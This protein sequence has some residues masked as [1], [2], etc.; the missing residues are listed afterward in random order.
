MEMTNILLG[1]SLLTSTSTLITFVLSRRKE[2]E[3]RGARQADLDSSIRE[4]KDSVTTMTRQ[5]VAQQSLIDNLRVLLELLL[6]QHNQNHGQEIR[7]AT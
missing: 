1:L 4:I 6:Q 3:I 7:R 5:I 2:A